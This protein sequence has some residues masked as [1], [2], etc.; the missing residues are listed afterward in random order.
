MTSPT[1]NVPELAPPSSK[2]FLFSASNAHP[3]SPPPAPAFKSQLFNTPRKFDAGIFSS[4]VEDS[5]IQSKAEE[6]TPEPRPKVAR[7]KT[8]QT[9][10]FANSTKRSGR[11]EV[12][13]GKFSDAALKK[14]QKR[15]SRKDSINEFWTAGGSDSDD[16]SDDSLQRQRR[17]HRGQHPQQHGQFQQYPQQSWAETHRDIPTI[18]SQY[19]QLGVNVSIACLGLYLLYAFVKTIQRDVEMKVQEY[20]AEVQHEIDVC[21]RDWF[22]NRCQPETLLPAM[23]EKCMEWKLCAE[24]DPE[25]IGRARVSAI[26]FAEIINS[27]IEPISYKAMVSCLTLLSSIYAND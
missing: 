11:G 8:A 18:L 1:K 21:N 22:A 16:S 19:L 3:P 20:S 25:L 13:R 17:K 9:S 7:Q 2:P 26:T 12:P 5:P 6:D 10:I 23:A 24:R 4:D 15:R 14:V 27:F